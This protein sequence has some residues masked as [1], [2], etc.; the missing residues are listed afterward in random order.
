MQTLNKNKSFGGKIFL[1]ICKSLGIKYIETER[2]VVFLVSKRY[3]DMKLKK[4]GI[5]FFTKE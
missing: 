1:K 4:L 5:N 3:A 2:N